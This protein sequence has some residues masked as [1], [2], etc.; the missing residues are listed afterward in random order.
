MKCVAIIELGITLFK[1]DYLDK[2]Y[3]KHVYDATKV[4]LEEA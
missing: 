3:I 4:N 1:A 2:T